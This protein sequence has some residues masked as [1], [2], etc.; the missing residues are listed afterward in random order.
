MLHEFRVGDQI[1]HVSF[2]RLQKSGVAASGG[3]FA[4]GSLSDK[5]GTLNFITF[6]QEVVEFLKELSSQ[7]VVVH[8]TVQADRYGGDGARQVVVERLELPTE[9]EDLSHLIPSTTKDI[10]FY[11]QLLQELIAGISKPHLKGLLTS[12]FSGD[13]YKK[14]VK[15]PAAMSYHHAYTGG[16]LE[17]SVDVARLAQAMARECPGVEPDFVVAGALLHDIGKIRELSPDVGFEYTE[18]GRYI[19]HLTLGA[20]MVE[21]VMTKVQDFPRQDALNL[22]HILLSH[23]GSMDK[24]SP[25]GCVTKESLIVH[26]ADEL[27]AVLNQFDELEKNNKGEWQYHKMLGRQVRVK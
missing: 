2:L 23:H 11:K 26:Y 5:S 10:D 15:S 13:T 16:L 27:N 1:R 7:V 8:G 22:M 19:G 4:R 9:D 6:N 3:M 18:V 12:L 25:V 20:L 14:F 17:H 21:K 24:G